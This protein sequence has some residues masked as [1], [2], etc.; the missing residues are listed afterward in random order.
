[1]KR[2]GDQQQTGHH[3]PAQR[4]PCPRPA[5]DGQ[6]GGHHQQRGQREQPGQRR[7]RARHALHLG[8][9]GEVELVVGEQI[10]AVSAA[11][12]QEAPVAQ[13]H[14]HAAPDVDACP[15]GNVLRQQPRVPGEDE[16][17]DPGSRQAHRAEVDGQQQRA[18]QRADERPGLSCDREQGEDPGT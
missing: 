1:V 10:G 14:P 18:E 6:L 16:Y 17:E 12:R 13:Q 9:Q 2:G 15:S 8:G 5:G 7:L 4:E 11:Q 3:G